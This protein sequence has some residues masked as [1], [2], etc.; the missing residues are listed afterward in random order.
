MKR[1]LHHHC[2]LGLVYMVLTA[3]WFSVIAWCEGRD[4][5]LWASAIIAL[6]TTIF[7]HVVLLLWQN[8]L[9]Y[10]QYLLVIPICIK[11]PIQQ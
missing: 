10:S 6:S 11:K 5:S 1:K 9:L 7:S 3:I 2:M 4:I 8:Y